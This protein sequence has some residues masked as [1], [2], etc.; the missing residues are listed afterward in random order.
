MNFVVGT[1]RRTV[2]K[3]AKKESKPPTQATAFVMD[4]FQRMIEQELQLIDLRA[5]KE[6]D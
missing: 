5:E 4:R 1:K 2:E 6:T 3:F